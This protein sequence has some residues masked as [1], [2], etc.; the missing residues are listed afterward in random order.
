MEFRG[1]STNSPIT[2][3]EDADNK[4]LSVTRGD[5]QYPRVDVVSPI[6]AGAKIVV[7]A[8]FKLGADS[9]TLDGDLLKLVQKD[10]DPNIAAFTLLYLRDGT[11]YNYKLRPATAGTS[12]IGEIDTSITFGTL[13][14]TEWTTVKVMVDLTNNTKD[15]YINGTLVASGLSVYSTDAGTTDYDGATSALTSCAVVHLKEGTGSLLV[16]D[17]C[18]YYVESLTE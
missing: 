11:L 4:Y 17:V 8:K 3:V 16:D 5:S 1:T 10:Y 7:E 13:S 9:S 14:A 6:N 12:I 2:V 18:Y 15:I